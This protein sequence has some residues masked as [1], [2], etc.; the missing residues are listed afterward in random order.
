MEV[1]SGERF[2]AFYGWMTIICFGLGLPCAFP[3]TWIPFKG[4]FTPEAFWLG[5][6]FYQPGRLTG[7][8]Y[9]AILI[10]MVKAGV[11]RGFTTRLAAVGQTAFTNYILTSVICTTIF[12]NY[13]FGLYGRLQRWQL[14][15]IVLGVWILQ[16]AASPIWLRYYRF[17]P[18]EWLW[19]SL[20]YWKKQPMRRRSDIRK[21]LTE[22]GLVT[23]AD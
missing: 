4:G 10:M 1:L 11:S 8:G 14:Y 15:A 6:I 13:G 23:V 3:S 16:L 19:R 12:E 17:G 21:T 7:L 18:M 5:F 22:P 9:C 2:Y 20:T